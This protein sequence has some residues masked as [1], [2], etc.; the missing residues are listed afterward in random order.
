MKHMV[1]KVSLGLCSCMHYAGV[2]STPRWSNKVHINILK[3]GRSKLIPGFKYTLVFNK[4]YY[5]TT[6]RV[7]EQMC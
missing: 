5:S 2:G 3:M 7:A 6:P 4:G 1:R